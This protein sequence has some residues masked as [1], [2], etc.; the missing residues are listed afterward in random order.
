[1]PTCKGR[2]D[3]YPKRS[4]LT[5]VR[6]FVDNDI[7]VCFAQ[8][9]IVDLWYP[10]ENGNL[11]NILDNGI[12]LAQLMQEEDFE[13]NLDLVTYNGAKA[14]YIQ[15]EY[16]LDEGKPANFIVL[17]AP[18]EFETIKNR[19]ECLSSVLNGKFL[20]KK[21]KREFEVKLNI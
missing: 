4:G 11:M 8:D 17:N 21:A 16:G 12:H 2:Q 3:T 18:N 14:L 10:A 19:A 1:M 7:N 15:D 20:F 9:S 13:K 5:R 6:E